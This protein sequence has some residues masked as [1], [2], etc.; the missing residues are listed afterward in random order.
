MLLDGQ[1]RNKVAADLE[2]HAN[3]RRLYTPAEVAARVGIQEPRVLKA[4][5]Y[6]SRYP[7]YVAVRVRPGLTTYAARTGR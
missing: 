1:V 7:G 3:T 5:E 4:L 2:A 6:L